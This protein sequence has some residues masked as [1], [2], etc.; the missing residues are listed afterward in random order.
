MLQVPSSVFGKHHAQQPHRRSVEHGD[1]ASD[2]PSGSD[3]D[4]DEA[5]PDGP[6]ERRQ[7]KE[8]CV[9]SDT[10]LMDEEDTGP[11]E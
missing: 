7:R 5:G 1:Q 9:P 10:N 4:S 3:S 11:A 2:T 8:S 6:T